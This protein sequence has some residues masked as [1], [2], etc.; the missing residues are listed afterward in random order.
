MAHEELLAE[1]N[2]LMKQLLELEAD[3]KAKNE[4]TRK[5]F[6]EMR[7][8]PEGIL[9]KA[10]S[11]L[12]NR[13]EQLM[14]Q[15]RERTDDLRRKTEQFNDDLIAELRELAFSAGSACASGS[16]RPNARR[17][18]CLLPVRHRRGVRRF[19]RTLLMARPSLPLP[20][21]ARPS[22]EAPH[23]P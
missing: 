3:Q 4:E 13:R 11:D 17:V 10:E 19:G 6:E 7:S 16:G 22:S 1:T 21:L 2:Q 15:S 20:Q 8:K 18:Q 14:Q 9:K 23:R 12:D 5:K